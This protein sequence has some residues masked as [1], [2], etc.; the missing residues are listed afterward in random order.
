MNSKSISQLIYTLTSLL[1]V[2]P[3]TFTCKYHAFKNFDFYLFPHK[4]LIKKYKTPF[5]LI[6]YDVSSSV[7]F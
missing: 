5:C 2:Y 6:T 7:L 3:Q 4:N 1:H